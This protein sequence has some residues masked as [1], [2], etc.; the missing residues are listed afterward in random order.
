MQSLIMLSLNFVEEFDL[1]SYSQTTKDIFLLMFTILR[2][3]IRLVKP[4][5]ITLSGTVFTQLRCCQIKI[6]LHNYEIRIKLSM[7]NS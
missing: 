1:Q 5:V 7:T 2:I 4:K 6:S 3:V